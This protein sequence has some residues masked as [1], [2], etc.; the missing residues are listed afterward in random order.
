MLAHAHYL[1]DGI[2]EYVGDSEKW[3]KANR[4]FVSVQMLLWQNGWYALID[5][6]NHNRS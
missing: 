5:L 6:T 3:D 4:H 1:L 2:K